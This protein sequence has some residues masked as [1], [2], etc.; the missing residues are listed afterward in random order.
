MMDDAGTCGRDENEVSPEVEL[1]EESFS[2]Q[3]LDD[4]AHGGLRRSQAQLIIP[5]TISE[6]F[7]CCRYSRCHSEGLLLAA[8]QPTGEL[9]HARRLVPRALS[10]GLL[11]GRLIMMASSMRRGGAEGDADCVSR[12]SAEPAAPPPRFPAED[13]EQD[14]LLEG[15]IVRIANIGLYID[16]GATLLGLLRCLL[17]PRRRLQRACGLRRSC[18]TWSSSRLPTRGTSASAC[19]RLGR[20]TKPSRTSPTWTACAASARGRGCRCPPTAS[21]LPRAGAT[22]TKVEGDDLDNA[23]WWI[24]RRETKGPPR[25]RAQRLPP[26][27]AGD[28]GDGRAKT[29]AAAARGP[30][31]GDPGREPRGF[32]RGAGGGP[33]ATPPRRRCSG[34]RGALGGA[35]GARGTP[36]RR[37][38]G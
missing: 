13:L 12:G 3:R 11:A 28:R 38:L 36:T 9:V 33:R 22:P 29:V 6:Y 31:Y 26:A 30:E 4:L 7:E 1:D 34:A 2:D 19:R 8:S 18:R 15:R 5:R 14:M 35:R 27:L 24:L 23:A 17:L 20:T 37:P 16:V 21:R 25:S 32:G 10:E